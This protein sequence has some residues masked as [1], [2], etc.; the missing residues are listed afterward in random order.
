MKEKTLEDQLKV[1]NSKL[2]F[3]VK[4]VEEFSLRG[5]NNH[6]VEA[7]VVAKPLGRDHPFFVGTHQEAEA[8]IDE[9]KLA[10]GKGFRKN[11]YPDLSKFK[12][13]Q[14]YIVTEP[15]GFYE[16]KSKLDE[17]QIEIRD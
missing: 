4:I 14:V 1:I 3:L 8:F 5:Y 10:N 6:L 13:E 7:L 16:L 11:S 12:V 15:K 17:A 2:D 9:H